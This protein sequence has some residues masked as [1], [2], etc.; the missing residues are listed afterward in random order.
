MP[1]L[2]SDAQVKLMKN[3]SLQLCNLCHNKVFLLGKA[4]VT[5]WMGKMNGSYDSPVLQLGKKRT[6]KMQCN[7]SR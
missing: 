4:A 6:F 1:K 2:H 7:Q 5:G 3:C